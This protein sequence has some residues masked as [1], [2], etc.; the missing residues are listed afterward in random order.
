M[1][2]PSSPAVLAP[3]RARSVRQAR[4]TLLAA[5]FHREL[6][7]ALVRGA[8]QAI[9]RAGIPAR[10][11]RV[12]WVPGAYELPLAATRLARGRSRPDAMVALGVLLRGETIQYGVLAQAVAQG[13]TD[14]TVQTGI[15]VTFGVIVAGTLAQARARAGGPMGNR[16]VE[17]A[18]AALALLRTFGR[19]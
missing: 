6:T 12:V 3:A 10:H 19:R 16:G 7:D 2:S 9:S 14:V 8:K 5:A 18:Q 17:A 1:S 13:L 11:V 4:I 15:P